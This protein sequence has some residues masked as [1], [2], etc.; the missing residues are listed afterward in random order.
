VAAGGGRQRCGQQAPADQRQW[1]YALES[2]GHTEK[3]L[4]GEARPNRVT[5]EGNP[6][7][8]KPTGTFTAA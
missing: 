4:V 2:V 6:F 7:A 8:R 1:L 3:V 5:P